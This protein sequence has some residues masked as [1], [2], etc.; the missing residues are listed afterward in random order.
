M[1]KIGR[2]IKKAEIMLEE[3]KDIKRENER[4]KHYIFHNE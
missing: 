3:K 1:F 4:L 2:V